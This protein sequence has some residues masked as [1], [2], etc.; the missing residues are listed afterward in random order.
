MLVLVFII[1]LGFIF[2]RNTQASHK[3]NLKEIQKNGEVTDMP[4]TI[5]TAAF[6]AGCFWGVE[7]TFRQIQGV[8]NTTVGYMGG[9][10]DNPTYKDV[11]TD[12]TGHAETVLIEYDPTEVSYNE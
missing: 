1:T 7:E 12:G 5:D 4:N 10:T 3:A 2:A 11:C 9:T 8:K 6:A